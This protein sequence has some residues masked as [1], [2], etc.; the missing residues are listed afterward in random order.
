MKKQIIV[1][2]VGYIPA[3]SMKYLY[4]KSEHIKKV[5]AIRSVRG[6]HGMMNWLEAEIV[7]DK[8]LA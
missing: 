8:M 2:G 7:I 3:G 1:N 6:H 4:R 5:H